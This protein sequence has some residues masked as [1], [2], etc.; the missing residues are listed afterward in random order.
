M[1][2][3]LQAPGISLYSNPRAAS[4]AEPYGE[5][6]SQVMSQA[7]F[8]AAHTE[9]TQW[10]G[11]APTP[12]VQLPGLAQS[13]GLKAL[14]YKDESKRFA[15]KSFKALGG[16]YAVF[17]LI[18]QA[19]KREYG[20]VP[21]PG[22]V[23]S[24]RYRDVISKLTVTCATDGNHGRSVAWGAQ[25][26]GCQ[27]VIYVHTH[28]SQGRADAIAAFGARVERVDGNYDD[29]V[30]HADNQ[31]RAHGWTVVSDTTYE[32]YRDIP[33]DVMHGYGVMAQ[34]VIEAMRDEPPTHVIVQ[35]GVGAFASAICASFWL[36]WGPRRPRFVVVEP[37]AAACL[38][39]SGLAGHLV[40]VHGEL[41]TV[42]AGLACGEVSPVA[43]EILRA[44][45]NDFVKIDDRF[46][47]QAMSMLAKPSSADKPIVSGET[48]AAGLG[49]LLAVQQS[50][51]LASALGIDHE[52][53]VLLLGSEGDTDP[54]I[55]QEVV[56]LTAQEVLAE[57]LA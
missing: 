13:L 7:G 50:S 26:F 22:D 38:F 3:I 37:Q 44:G 54:E 23:L 24:G 39:E 17:R 25:T 10:P 1:A 41:D 53:R 21:G 33:I 11:Y 49:M 18:Q 51:G 47:L 43:W 57:E 20:H 45:A 48:G 29:S 19:V 35:A 16:A 34:E 32:G 2:E 6:R 31:A 14:Y 28:V 52:S 55:Y 8:A 27:C 5:Q 56:G 12:L 9:I 15:L 42:M 36:A 46:A 40:A 30:R 4:V